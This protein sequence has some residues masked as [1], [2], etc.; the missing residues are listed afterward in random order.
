MPRPRLL[1]LAVVLA[2]AA[3]TAAEEPVP[4]EWRTPAEAADFR[5]TPSYDETIA[6]LKRLE[7]RM[8]SMK[9]SFYGSSGEGRPL[10]LVVVSKEGAFTGKRA[11]RIP[12]PIVLVQNGIHAGEID[13]KDACLMILRDLALGRRT[14]L[15]DAATL[16]ILPIY[17]VDGHERVS[18]FNRPNQDGPVEGM[19]FRTTTAGLDLNRDYMKLASEEGRSLAALVNAWRPHLFVD[20]HV[21]DGAEYDLVLTYHHP[22]A[23]QAPGPV[24][25]W[26]AAHVPPAVEAT[27]RTGRR[28]GPYVDLRNELDPLAGFGAAILPPRFSTGYLVLRNRP[29]VLVETHSYKPYR[30]RVLAN[31]DFLVALLAEVGKDPA[32]LLRAVSEAEAATVAAGRADA[33]PSSVILTWEDADTTERVRVPFYDWTVAPSVVSGKPLLRYR[34]GV[35]REVEIP[36]FHTPKPGKTVARPRGYLVPPG[37]PAIEARLRGHG[38]RI[39]RL[40]AAVDLDVETQRVSSPRFAERPYQGLTPVASM[41]VERHVERRKIPAGSLFIPADQPDFGVAAHLLEAEA[42][43]SLLSWGL[44]SNVFE[45]KEYV[46]PRVLE[47]LAAKMLEDPKVAAEWRAAL[48]DEAFAKDPEARHLWFYRHTP[49]W[50]ETVGL[51]PVYRVMAPARFA[52]RPWR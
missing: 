1:L 52:T 2:L 11:R 23:P 12:K 42:P 17:N 10:P 41:T 49:Y 7:A 13:G 24:A 21:T 47:G 28:A 3:R 22:E 45:G 30:D 33:P 31:R 20:D 25:A 6:F 46:E 19:G 48:R 27:S 44:I 34:R 18:R 5:A 39:E 32:G 29:A 16:M 9:L 38:L 35:L 8:P 36:W 50:D 37:W 4:P 26:L 15:L 43:D 40:E 51:L 14:E